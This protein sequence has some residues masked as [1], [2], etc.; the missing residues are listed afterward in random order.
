MQEPSRQL[1]WH[2]AINNTLTQFFLKLRALVIIFGIAAGLGTAAGLFLWNGITTTEVKIF[3]VYIEIIKMGKLPEW[4][5]TKFLLYVCLRIFEHSIILTVFLFI[6]IFFGYQHF[7]AKLYEKKYIRGL[8]LLP[9]KA[10]I[11]NINS[12]E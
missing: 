5:Y 10:L 1:G 11:K 4:K 3:D 9:P 8:K 6:V 12:T 7:S 2:T